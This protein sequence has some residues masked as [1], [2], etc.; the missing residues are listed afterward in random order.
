MRNNDKQ[1]IRDENGNIVDKRKVEAS[2][3][4]WARRKQQGTNFFV[5][6]VVDTII[7]CLT[8]FFLVNVHTKIFAQKR[9]KFR[10]LLNFHKFLFLQT[11]PRAENPSIK[12]SQP[13]TIEK[14]ELQTR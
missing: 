2:K 7:L 6:E 8:F 1:T 4:L 3:D 9:I 5:V 13:S 10:N 12:N 11:K 14:D